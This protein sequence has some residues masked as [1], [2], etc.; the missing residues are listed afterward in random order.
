MAFRILFKK[1]LTGNDL[2]G[3]HGLLLGGHA[4]G[5][6]ALSVCGTVRWRWQCLEVDEVWI[7]VYGP[8]RH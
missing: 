2:V 6:S 1:N 3:G 8:A 4:S 5:A 7:G